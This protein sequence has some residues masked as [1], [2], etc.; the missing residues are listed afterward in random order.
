M[1]QHYIEIFYPGSFVAESSTAKVDSRTYPKTL[2]KGAYAFRFYDREE[3]EKD[4]EILKGN[5]KNY[6]VTYFP[7]AVAMDVDEV[8][9][10]VPDSRILVSNMEGN[11]WK[12]VIKTR[13][14]NFLPLDGD[15]EI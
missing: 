14:G 12:K 11:G 10:K 6:S 13:R 2:P 1:L 7:G 4:G 15:A 9:A 5:A 3:I 8:K